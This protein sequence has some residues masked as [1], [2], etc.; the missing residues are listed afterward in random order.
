MQNKLNPVEIERQPQCGL[1]IETRSHI[2]T[3][4]R[5]WEFLPFSKPGE[6]TK[7]FIWSSNPATPPLTSIFGTANEGSE[8]HL[9]YEDPMNELFQKETPLDFTRNPSDHPSGLEITNTYIKDDASVTVPKLHAVGIQVPNSIL[10]FNHPI[11][12]RGYSATSLSRWSYPSSESNDGGECNHQSVFAP[13]SEVGQCKNSQTQTL[14]G[15][16]FQSGHVTAKSSLLTAPSQTAMCGMQK[17]FGKKQKSSFMDFLHGGKRKKMS[18]QMPFRIRSEVVKRTQKYGN[19]GY[20]FAPRQQKATRWHTGYTGAPLEE[21]AMCG[22]QK[23]TFMEFLHEDKREMS[24]QMP[25]WMNNYRSSVVERTQKDGNLGHIFSP[26]Q[27]EPTRGHTGFTEAPLEEK[28]M[29]GNFG[30]KQK[31]TFMDFLQ[32][33]KR[34]MSSQMPFWIIS[35]DVERTQKDGNSG[36][37]FAPQQQEATRGHNGFTDAPR[38]E[39]ANCVRQQNFGK[40][41]KSTFMDFL[42]EG[43]REMSS[44]MP[45]RINNIRSAVVE[46]TQK[47]G[48]SA[49]AFAPQHQEATRGHNDFTDAPWK[50]MANCGRQQNFGE[51]Q[52]STFMDFLHWGKRE[53]SSQM[54]FRMNKNKSAV[55]DRTQKYGHSGHAFAPQ[56][57]EAIRG[58]TGYTEAPLKEMAKRERRQKHSKKKESVRF[59]HKIK[60]K[61]SFQKHKTFKR[62]AVVERQPKYDTSGVQKEARQVEATNSEE[63]ETREIADIL[64]MLKQSNQRK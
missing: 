20:G 34:K 18:S 3:G 59:S 47:Y 16:T 37:I 14:H 46:R 24:S 17:S 33:G 49:H 6:T 50:D 19:S 57:Q 58:H 21:M 44:Q 38:T 30:G 40:K 10:N 22:K 2:P 27:Q 42:H 52:K 53:M 4:F 12:G 41:K 61:S 5:N 62:E 56:H 54:P 36:H 1:Q 45:F 13:R 39:T 15:S 35:T 28:A 11:K 8:Q 64:L 32:K 60:R 26:R 51:K 55:V 63:A 43:K 31:S 23:S 25:F 48:N 7:D 29:C 9:G